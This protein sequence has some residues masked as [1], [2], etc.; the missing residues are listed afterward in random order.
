LYILVNP[1]TP[2]PETVKL[3]TCTYQRPHSDV[4]LNNYVD[5]IIEYAIAVES[6]GQG[7]VDDVL[8][9]ENS[10]AANVLECSTSNI[11]GVWEKNGEFHI[12]TPPAEKTLQGIT[13]DVLLNVLSKNLPAN[14]IFAEKDIP[15]ANLIEGTTE[16]LLTSS[17]GPRNVRSINDEQIGDGKVG[18]VTTAIIQALDDFQKQQCGLI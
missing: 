7:N 8:Y 15:L 4:K 2:P 14:F 11:F 1:Y 3:V 16:V 10:P 13:R 5:A 9:T 17:T 12:V 18:P 6:Y